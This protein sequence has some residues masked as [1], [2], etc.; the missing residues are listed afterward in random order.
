M[1]FIYGASGHGKV[2]LDC[3]LEKG[4]EVAGFIDSDPQKT[5]FMHLPVFRPEKLDEAEASVIYGIGNNTIRQTLAEK[6]HTPSPVVVHPSAQLSRYSH[7]GEGTVLFHNS[8]VQ[9]G[10]R[11]GKHCIINTKASVD[12]DCILEDYVHISPG[13]ILCGNVKIGKGTWVGAG[14]IIIQGVSIGNNVMVGAGSVIR[15][16]VPDGVLIVGNPAKVMRKLK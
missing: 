16:D 11:I 7:V 1:I 4:N 3:L 13:A 10:T 6:H 2:I 8:V 9:A 14:S 5:E 12:H 15:K